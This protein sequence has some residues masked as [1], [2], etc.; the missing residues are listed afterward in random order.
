MRRCIVTD[1][2]EVRYIPKQTGAVNTQI[3][4]GWY[5]GSIGQ[6]MVE[7]P[8]YPYEVTST[9]TGT[10]PNVDVV[11][12]LKLYINDTLTS[13]KSKKVYIGAFE[14]MS[15]DASGT[16]TPKLYSISN[17]S[18]NSGNTLNAAD[19]TYQIGRAHV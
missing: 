15:D 1:N 13:K 4:E 6:C 16:S 2:G 12:E 17:I 9:T 19:V 11:Y 5:N 7:I 10:L 3:E 18:Y 8:E 14:A